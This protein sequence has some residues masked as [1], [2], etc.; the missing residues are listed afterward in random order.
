MD[1]QLSLPDANDVRSRTKAGSLAAFIRT[2]QAAREQELLKKIEMLQR[3]NDNGKK[4]TC[5][6]HVASRTIA[7]Y[8]QPEARSREARGVGGDGK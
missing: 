7:C 5:V 2:H 8:H 1:L 4:P 6:A 3:D